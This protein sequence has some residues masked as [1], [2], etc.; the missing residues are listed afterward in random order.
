MT[1]L[2]SPGARRSND[3]DAGRR[4]LAAASL[5]GVAVLGLRIAADPGAL[6]ASILSGLI[7]AA[8][9]AGVTLALLPGPGETVPLSLR[10]GLAALLLITAG[11]YGAAIFWQ[12]WFLDLT[13]DYQ[14]APVGVSLGTAVFF[15]RDV[16]PRRAWALLAALGI[17]AMALSRWP[18]LY[19]LMPVQ[20]WRWRPAVRLALGTGLVAGAAGLAALPPA[21]H[22]LSAV[23]RDA[24]ERW[25]RATGWGS[26]IILPTAHL[27]PGRSDDRPVPGRF[28]RVLVFVMEGVAT[29]EFDRWLAGP[30]AGAGFLQAAAATATR[31]RGYY[32][33]N[34]ESRTARTAMLQSLMIPFEAY[35]ANW[36]RLFGHVYD[37]GGLVEVLNRNGWHTALAIPLVETP[38]DLREL[39]WRTRLGIGEADL[40]QKGWTCLAPT[41][42]DRGCEDLILLDQID[43]LLAG[44][45]PVFLF[46]PFLFGHT[47]RW[48]DVT[49]LEP[50]AYYD[51]YLTGLVER[52]R[53][54]RALDETLIVVTAD[55]GPRLHAQ[56]IDPAWYEVPLWLVNPTFPAA[57]RTGFFTSTDFQAVLVAAM[58]QGVPPPAPVHPV[59]LTTG[60]SG[61][62]VFTCALPD[63]RF[64]AFRIRREG[65]VSVLQVIGPDR[66]H[67]GPCIS[68]F[69]DYRRRFAASQ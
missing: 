8:F 4:A 21:R 5:L 18:T 52:L 58:T 26:G 57:P 14:F 1:H 44:P 12:A 47:R 55:H 10:R 30:S 11:G 17:A 33:V 62:R 37:D 54:R 6:A 56:V 51:R 31:Y 50:I 34:Q 40:A 53:R 28:R 66:D 36:R 41:E 32:T 43:A 67:L 15:V 24:R 22:P 65:L 46:Q 23:V 60:P 38:V 42:F 19:H 7:D 25:H 48:R 39:P 69:F 3:L 68:T 13:T 9:L 16:A 49:G 45:D 29:P 27:S 59:R 61:H 2:R 64:G 63:G 20:P 35:D